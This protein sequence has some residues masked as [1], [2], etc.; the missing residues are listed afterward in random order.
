MRAVVRRQV[1]ALE[2]KDA[3]RRA[4]TDPV[5]LQYK[6]VADIGVLLD[7][8]QRCVRRPAV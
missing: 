6:Q 4:A 3:V 7:K 8:Q 5:L 2:A 1:E